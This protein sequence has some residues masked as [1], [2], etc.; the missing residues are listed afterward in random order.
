MIKG[1]AVKTGKTA[2]AKKYFAYCLQEK[3]QIL[4]FIPR[5][6]EWSNNEV[7][8]AAM[9]NKSRIYRQR[10]V[11]QIDFYQDAL[12][13]IS[14]SFFIAFKSFQYQLFWLDVCNAL[15]SVEND[16]EYFWE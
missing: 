7:K 3:K 2:G 11:P 16:E 14:S 12:N 10:M 13:H 6:D 9:S 4:T 8:P 15:F 1:I 5:E